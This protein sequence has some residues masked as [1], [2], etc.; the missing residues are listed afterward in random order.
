[1]T[2]SP[3]AAPQ[4]RGLGVAVFAVLTQLAVSATGLATASGFA[5]ATLLFVVAPVT[6]ATTMALWLTVVAR[7]GGRA[8]LGCAAAAAVSLLAYRVGFT[9]PLAAAALVLGRA[10]PSEDPDHERA[11]LLGLALAG[12]VLLAVAALVVLEVFGSPF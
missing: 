11:G 5:T 6:L 2:P 9:V 12:A 8:G 1:M 7:G 4:A 10:V 3:R